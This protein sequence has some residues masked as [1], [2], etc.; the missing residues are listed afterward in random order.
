M[1]EVSRGRALARLMRDADA[2]RVVPSRWP[3]VEAAARQF[4]PCIQPR[5]GSV[6]FFHAK[7]RLEAL[8]QRERRDR[9]VG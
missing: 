7:A 1:A 2:A 3:M 9:R 4:S 5:L 8:G 6:L